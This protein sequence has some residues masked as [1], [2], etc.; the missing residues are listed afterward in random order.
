MFTTPAT[1][2]AAHSLPVPPSSDPV[3]DA[4]TM[5]TPRSTYKLR[6]PRIRQTAARPFK[7]PGKSNRPTGATVQGLKQRLQSLRSALRIRGIPDPT[8]PSVGSTPSTKPMGDEELE[9]LALR[10]RNAARE[11]AQ[12]LWGLVK[13]SVDQDSWGSAEKRKRD[14]WEWC[15]GPQRA[16]PAEDANLKLNVGDVR[17][18]LTSASLDVNKLCREMVKKSKQPHVPREGAFPP[19]EDTYKD[20]EVEEKNTDD[21]DCER[22]AA[23][24]HTLG[25]MLTSLGIP[26]EV[27]GWQEEEG[28][29][30]DCS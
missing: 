26:H 19:N 12:D 23:R 13:D 20:L 29:F 16:H 2:K 18:N 22:D 25:T 14:S 27:L 7:P 4:D 21:S 28:E 1:A 3:F 15:T 11:A 17:V 9:A 5:C 10:W 30:V 6:V 8:Q 24:S